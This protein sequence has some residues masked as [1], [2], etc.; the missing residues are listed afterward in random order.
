[1]NRGLKIKVWTELWKI[2]TPPMKTINFHSMFYN[3]DIYQCF[4]S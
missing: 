4:I 2:I 3:N 1:M